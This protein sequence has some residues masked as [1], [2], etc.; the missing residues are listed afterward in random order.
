MNRNAISPLSQLGLSE[1]HLEWIMSEFTSAKQRFY[2]RAGDNSCFI[3]GT[4]DNGS[5]LALDKKILSLHLSGRF[6]IAIPA[7]LMMKFF[8]IELSDR[9]EIQKSSLSKFTEEVGYPL[10]MKPNKS[11][12]LSCV[13]L[14]QQYEDKYDIVKAVEYCLD[15]ILSNEEKEYCKIFPGSMRRFELPFGN[16]HQILDPETLQPISTSKR[17]MIEYCMNYQQRSSLTLDTLLRRVE[18]VACE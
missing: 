1:H 17:M 9:E 16:G 18:G 15:R 5:M 6:R 7:N 2:Y 14:L 3:P 10:V 8:A 12:K 13:Y 11:T 4:D